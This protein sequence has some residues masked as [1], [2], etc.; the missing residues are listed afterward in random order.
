MLFNGFGAS[1]RPVTPPVNM[2]FAVKAG[3]LLVFLAAIGGATYAVQV[4]LGDGVDVTGAAMRAAA[5]H[6]TLNATAGHTVTYALSGSNRGAQDV[7]VVARLAGGGFSGVS[8]A[9]LLPREGN[10]TV[11]VPVAVGAAAQ[12]GSTALTLTLESPEGRV[13]RAQTGAA[14]LRVLGPAPGFGDGV[15]IDVTYVGR[16]ADGSVFNT[17][18]ADL[19]SL[20]FAQAAIYQPSQ[21]GGF[22]ITGSSRPPVIQGFYDILQGMQAGESRTAT[23]PAA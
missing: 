1:R 16:L 10:L 2:S 11:F 14:T 6:P 21:P 17:N 19:L 23:V 22:T 4:Q 3:A 13:L 18:D 20:H 12:P 15:T 7:R 9:T 8:P 5:V